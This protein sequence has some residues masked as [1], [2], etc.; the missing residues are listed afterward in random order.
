M[1]RDTRSGSY[2][3]FTHA[4]TLLPAIAL[5]CTT[6][7][8]T[9]VT[10]AGADR[11]L[12]GTHAG[13]TLGSRVEE[14]LAHDDGTAEEPVAQRPGQKLA[15]RFQAPV[16][17]THVTALEIYIMDD[18][19]VN[20]YDPNAPSTA[21]FEVWVWRP[22]P[23]MLPGPPANDGYYPFPDWY[24]YPEEAWVRVDLPKPV[25]ITDSDLFPDK[26]FFVGIEWCYRLNPYVGLDTDSPNA[27]AS[28]RWNWS[29]W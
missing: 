5:A 19:L 22:T 4:L 25:D 24:M 21:P 17:A 20:P 14:V 3:Q 15:V 7:L 9:S 27:G 8:L 18:G 23:D 26:K 16:W 2:R 11:V 13:L 29:V 28:L 6:L 10:A 1:R 12:L